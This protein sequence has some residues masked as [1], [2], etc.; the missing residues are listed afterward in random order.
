MFFLRIII[1]F[2]SLYSRWDL[3][4]SEGDVEKS[5]ELTGH[6]DSVS[7]LSLSPDGNHLLSN[8]MDG[9]LFQWDIRPFILDEQNRCELEFEGVKHSNEKNLLK[10]AWSPDQEYVTSGSAD[11]IVKVWSASTG[12]LLYYLPGH[13]GSVNEVIFHPTVPGIIASCGSDRTIFLGELV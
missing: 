6:R 4:G 13:K 2:F 10:C 7:G 5:L 9:H 11:S 12:K 1:I 8:G 3:R